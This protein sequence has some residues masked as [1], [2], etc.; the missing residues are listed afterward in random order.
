MK[1]FVQFS[2]SHP[3][4]TAMF[5]AA[6]ILLGCLGLFRLETALLP[7]ISFPRLT[8]VTRFADESPSGI[9]KRVTKPIEEALSGVRGLVKVNSSSAQGVSVVRLVFDWKTDINFAAMESREKLDL[10]R[11]SLPQDAQ[12]PVVLKYDPN[13]APLMMLACVPKSRGD[14]ELR[15]FIEKSIKPRFRRIDGVGGV[16]ISG[17]YLPEIHVNVN[18]AKLYSVKMTLSDIVQM[19]SRANYNTPAGPLPEGNREV[20]VRTIGE[21][22]KVSEIGDIL[23]TGKEG[24]GSF[25]LSLLADTKSGFKDKKSETYFNNTACVGLSIFSESGANQVSTASRVRSVINDLQ[26]RYGRRLDFNLVVDR[27]KYISNAI[28][29]VALAALIGGILAFFVILYFLKSLPE[30]IILALS[31][32]ICV[33][34]TLFL[35]F[36]SGISLNVI[37][38]GGL[39]LGLGMTVD[40][41]IVVE[42]ASTV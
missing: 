12:R 23:I 35:M 26:R 6:L 29:D 13:T 17:G 20:M 21:F 28:N 40:S 5:G 15:R 18:P 37:S 4:T 2:V 16:K 32:P 33:A 27:S 25:R 30:S 39:A 11:N 36:L 24:K 38:L 42:S 31:I 9:E 34:A 7:D 14:K 10:I 41:G 1:K 3:V 22:K 8:V 19:I